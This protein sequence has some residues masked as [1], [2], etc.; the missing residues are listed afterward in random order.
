MVC[1]L[2]I[3]IIR[4][5]SGSNVIFVSKRISLRAVIKVLKGAICTVLMVKTLPSVCVVTWVLLENVDIILFL[6]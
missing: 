2:S 5:P 4:I 1:D 3:L 6:I